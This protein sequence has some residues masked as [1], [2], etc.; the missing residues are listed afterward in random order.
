MFYLL[1]YLLEIYFALYAHSLFVAYLHFSF[2]PLDFILLLFLFFFFVVAQIEDALTF[3]LACLYPRH[4]DRCVFP[5]LPSSYGCHDTEYLS[6]SYW[7]RSAEGWE[8][9]ETAGSSLPFLIQLSL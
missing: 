7:Q 6:M 8:G 2:F 3:S 5:C 9:N 4:C 1:V